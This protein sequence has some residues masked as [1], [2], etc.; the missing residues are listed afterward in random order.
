M[1]FLLLKTWSNLKLFMLKLLVWKFSILWPRRKRMSRVLIVKPEHLGDFLISLSAFQELCDHYHSKG[2]E[3][4]ILLP[5]AFQPL[6]ERC[7]L[8]DHVLGYHLLHGD[9]TFRKRYALWCKLYAMRFSV[10]VT[11][12]YF[13]SKYKG[14]I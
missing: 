12:N 8:F 6:A 9:L 5:P 10:V 3:V 7:P 13:P 14:N 11:T 4:Y 2:Y 1:K